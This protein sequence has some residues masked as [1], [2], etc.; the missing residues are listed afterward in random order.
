P[1]Q[2]TTYT[3][4]NIA[5]GCETQTTVTVTVHS[6]PNVEVSPSAPEICY[7]ESTTL[8]A[9]GN[10]TSYSWA[11]ATGL[12]ATSGST[13]VANPLQSIVYTLTA[14]AAGCTTTREVAVVVKP[15]VN[16]T[17][18]PQS[19]GICRGQGADVIATGAQNY[20]WQP[21]TGVTGLGPPGSYRLS[22]QTTTTYTLIGTASGCSGQTTTTVTVDT[23]PTVTATG[24]MHPLCP[25]EFATLSASGDGTSFVWQP[26]S[27][28]I[29]GTTGA[30]V[31][32]SPSQTTTYTVR[33]YSTNQLCVSEATVTVQV[34]P[35]PAIT[36][37]IP[38]PMLCAGE[39]VAVALSGANNYQWN[40]PVEENGIFIL[41]PNQTT[42]YT[43]TGISEN[44]C[45][46]RLEYLVT[47]HPLPQ[48]RLESDR[49]T[50]CRGQSARLAAHG[51]LSYQ[52]APS[53]PGHSDSGFTIQPQNTT[54]FT[55]VGTDAN[56][57]KD[58]AQ[59]TI[60]VHPR[61]TIVVRAPEPVC[62]GSAVVVAAEGATR[63][64]VLPNGEEG[65]PAR[66]VPQASGFY[67]V[68]GTDENGCRDTA[69]V[70]VRVN[71][72]P[73]LTISPA[74][75]K[76]CAGETAILTASGALAYVWKD[77]SGEILGF[78][79]SLKLSPH[80]TMVVILEGADSNGCSNATQTTITVLGL[81]E[82][83]EFRDTAVC[84]GESVNIFARSGGEEIKFH[85][86]SMPRGGRSLTPG[87]V[88]SWTTPPIERETVYWLETIREGCKSENRTPVT[89]KPL[90]R[91]TIQDLPVQTVCP[92]KEIVLTLPDTLSYVWVKS[93]GSHTILGPALA[94]KAEESQ[95]YFV[96]ATDGVCEA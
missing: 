30:N 82:A 10:A 71:P 4:R 20:F 64:R 85:V 95:A 12:S 50:L 11:P 34:V 75:V 45:P 27:G 80:R 22:P 57:C 2:T 70:Y 96:Y 89:I 26:S 78:G 77:E 38:P 19:L 33:A 54:T 61:P 76:L 53:V 94:L 66:F 42:L 52:W 60:V 7:G 46:T 40:P 88:G 29:N 5:P 44:G 56:G 90:P 36:P 63:Y 32:A 67:L 93:D 68:E 43:I 47:V 23:P 92:G 62:A 79:D 65:N 48:I 17:V 59:I 31:V 1:S 16:V 24:P 84:R 9:S 21:S 35:T 6:P 58:T 18:A 72:L 81:P 69:T 25:G 28:L 87:P 3:V 49:L 55:V 74:N 86:Y 73:T 14:V 39:S 83:Y 91:P 13:V 8:V 37:S 51:A 41:S 15:P